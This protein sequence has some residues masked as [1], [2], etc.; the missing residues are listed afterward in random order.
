MK[1]II[2]KILEKNNLIINKVHKVHLSNLDSPIDAIYYNGKFGGRQLFSFDVPIEKCVNIYG[3]QFHLPSSHHFTATLV[4]YAKNPNIRFKD[5]K[6]CKF[7]EG[8]TPENLKTLYFSYSNLESINHNNDSP[9]LCYNPQVI[10]LPWLPDIVYTTSEV[11]GK[12]RSEAGLSFK[13][14]SQSFGPVSQAKGNLEFSRLINTYNSI[15]SKGY[16]VDYFHNQISGYFIKSD[17]DYRFIIQ[18]GN[19]RTAS[20]A[21]LGIK[22]IP[23]I[24]RYDYPR[25]IDINDVELWPQV[26]NGNV[27]KCDA[28]SIFYAMFQGKDFS[29]IFN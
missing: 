5:S 27:T 6:L 22:S 21:A 7:Y 4:E 23:V 9:L 18:N 28:E 1:Q 29:A 19:H 3:Y 13:E 25:V 20:L 12:E 15:S 24:F 26:K 8:F 10:T 16:T 14:G 11:N 17:S 2:K